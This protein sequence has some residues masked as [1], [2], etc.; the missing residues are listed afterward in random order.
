MISNAIFSIESVIEVLF[1]GPWP[2]RAVRTAVSFRFEPFQKIGFGL[3]RKSLKDV[4]KTDPF[5]MSP[6]R[7]RKNILFLCG[8]SNTRFVCCVLAIKVIFILKIRTTGS[9]KA[10]ILFRS[11]KNVAIVNGIT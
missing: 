2:I 4:R 5:E 3:L 1:K 6:P 9:I 8:I 11:D 10:L 7:G